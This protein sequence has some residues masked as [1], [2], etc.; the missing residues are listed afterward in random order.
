MGKDLRPPFD[1][2]AVQSCFDQPIYD[3][4]G[5][6]ELFLVVGPP[7]DG[8]EAAAA[9]E[10]D[11]RELTA[12]FAFELWV[13]AQPS[14]SRE[15]VEARRLAEACRRV[16]AIA[17]TDEAEPGAETVHPFFGAGGLYAA[18]SVRLGNDGP[19][20]Q[21]AGEASVIAALRAVYLLRQDALKMEEIAAR[22]Q[23]L[24]PP[25]RGRSEARSIKK[26][27]AG[28]AGLYWAVWHREPGIVRDVNGEPG[29]PFV[30]LLV[31]VVGAVQARLGGPQAF[32]FT[33]ASLA[34]TWE[35]L[36][37][38]EKMKWRSEGRADPSG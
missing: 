26:L 38:E 29:G 30:R 5:L 24:V 37:P 27:V 7:R 36:P 14:A 28:L 15:E 34:K 9:A 20:A 12:G 10:F 23:R 22:R 21:S 35:R 31:H 11:L 13:E 2:A 6:R 19:A 1:W 17:G 4:S 25:K 32:H 33:P 3:A 18:A 8:T 16:L